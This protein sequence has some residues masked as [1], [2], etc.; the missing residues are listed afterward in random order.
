[1]ATKKRKK[2]AV[3]AT[4][5]KPVRQPTRR[6]VRA[7][8]KP[9]A[10]VRTK[11]KPSVKKPARKQP[12]REKPGKRAKPVVKR[13]VARVKTPATL[14]N[15]RRGAKRISA[16]EVKR[17]AANA[18]RRAAYAEARAA[19]LAAQTKRNKQNRKRRR[20]RKV[21]RDYDRIEREAIEQEEALKRRIKAQPKKG[22]FDDEFYGEGGYAWKRRDGT[23]A[24]QPTM[25]RHLHRDEVADMLESLNTNAGTTGTSFLRRLQYLAEL[26]GITVREVW[27]SLQNAGG[28]KGPFN[29]GFHDT[30][31]KI[32]ILWDVPVKEVYTLWFSP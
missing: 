3:V 11:P 15:T 2:P 9:R 13:P 16:A 26:N 20:E 19:E 18:H 24:K 21:A 14:G 10:P 23:P 25:L 17:L 31:Q 5:K 7:K 22:A 4:K 29:K 8:P 6:V 12:G 28:G 32:A 1:M 27:S 30:A